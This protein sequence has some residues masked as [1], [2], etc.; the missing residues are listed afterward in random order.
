M[1]NDGR[2][3]LVYDAE[4]RTVSS[5]YQGATANYSYDGNSLRVKKVSGGTT[6]VYGF[7]GT[8]VTAEYVNGAVPAPPTREY[9]YAGSQ[10]LAKIEGATTNYYH[11]DHLSVRITTD[12]SGTK[13]GD[14]GHYPF[15]ESWYASS[16]TTK[17]QFTS[18]ERDTES[19]NDYAMLRYH[20]NR[21][22]RFS[23]PD[24]LAGSIFDPQSLNGY[25]YV[26]NDPVGLVDPLGL[27]SCPPG[28]IP[29]T[30]IVGGELGGRS[31]DCSGAGGDGGATGF[32]FC[33]FFGPGGQC[34]PLPPLPPKPP[35]PQPPKKKCVGDNARVIGPGLV[36]NPPKEGAFRGVEVTAG[37]AAIIP[38][39]FQMTKS[40][41]KP[42]LGGIEGVV[43]DP[44]TGV[45]VAEFH[46]VTD[47][48]G[49]PEAQAKLRAQFP[50]SFILELNGI[51]ETGSM[52]KQVILFADPNLPCPQGTHEER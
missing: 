32:Q 37:T 40:Q 27:Q 34:P 7:S 14:Q 13:I 41:L 1:T 20:V 4:N 21:L 9:I 39:Q 29:V 38:A 43:I 36:K 22:G 35:A 11:A 28:C 6:T 18:Y 17:W 12:S 45:P 19:V 33:P 51:K 23:S 46:G 48:I 16:T 42:F 26:L 5:T 49:P 47:V 50:D 2:N 31:C 10:L 44:R 24:P 25:A 52:F 15:G 8:K 30:I 3:A